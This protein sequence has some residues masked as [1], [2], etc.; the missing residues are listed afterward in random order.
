MDE[1]LADAWE[2]LGLLSNWVKKIQNGQPPRGWGSPGE[3]EFPKG[4]ARTS[5]VT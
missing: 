3:T 4:G 5:G 1:V 2:P